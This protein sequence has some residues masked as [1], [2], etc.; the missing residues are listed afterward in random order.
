[1]AGP[2][3]VFMPGLL[4]DASVFT[5]QVAALAPHAEIRVADFSRYN[6]LAAMAEAALG[7]FE[8]AVVL[9]GFSMGGRAALQAVR[10]APDRV[11]ALCLMDTGAGPARA[12]EAAVRQ[13]LV[14]LARREGMRALAA[15]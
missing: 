3:I 2:R 12:D 6:S 5:A 14:D 13:P 7:L 10:Q 15:R 1:M 9:V 8:G 4:C 11:A